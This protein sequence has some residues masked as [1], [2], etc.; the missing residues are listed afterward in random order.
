MLCDIL[1]DEERGV[2]FRDGEKVGSAKLPY[3]RGGTASGRSHP[4][5]TKDTLLAVW[6]DKAGRV[7]LRLRQ[8]FARSQGVY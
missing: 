6:I 1:E 3:D 7:C 5:R 4:R 2:D 8:L